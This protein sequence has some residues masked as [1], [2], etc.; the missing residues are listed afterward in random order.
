MTTIS[1]E[2]IELDNTGVARIS[3]TRT[4]VIQVVMDKMAHAW[5]SEDIQKQYPH[6]ALAEVHAA[7]AYY[8]DHQKELDLQ[9]S[10][11]LKEADSLRAASGESPVVARLRAKGHLP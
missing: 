11:D 6:L 1:T 5:G 8:Y 10:E 2:H 7:M 4:K 9:V 3:G